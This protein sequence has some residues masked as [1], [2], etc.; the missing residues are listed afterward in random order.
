MICDKCE[1]NIED[2]LDVCCVC[3]A[4][5]NE[6]R[7]RECRD[8]R[9]VHSAPARDEESKAFWGGVCNILFSVIGLIIGLLIYPY[10]SY[11][12]GTFIKG[13]IT[14]FILKMIAAFVIVIIAFS[15]V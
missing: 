2:G 13:W 1:S 12:R 8:N 3:G 6:Q 7:R 9:P 11:A 4:D 14:M 15:R 5:L 10:Q